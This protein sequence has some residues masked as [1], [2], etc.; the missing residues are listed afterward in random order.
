MVRSQHSALVEQAQAGD[1]RAF[2]ALLRE[3]DDK[4]RGLAFQLLGTQAAMDDALQDAYLKAYT[5]LPRFRQDAA[6]GTWL[7][8]VVYTTCIDHLRRTNR[9]R[10]VGLSV[11]P[12]EPTRHDQAE[13]Y[14]TRDEVSRALATLT[15]DHKTALILID[16]EGLSYEEASVVLDTPAGTIASRLNRARTAFRA[17]LTTNQGLT[18]R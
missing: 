12:D 17:A 8:R 13:D 11:V 2:T 9:R 10:E 16:R 14:A 18:D 1:Q 4:M 3:H 7:Y 5:A 6:F 15:P